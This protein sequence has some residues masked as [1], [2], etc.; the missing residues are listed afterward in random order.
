TE[1]VN[2][3]AEIGVLVVR[4]A[5]VGEGNA[6]RWWAYLP[7][8]TLARLAT[9]GGLVPYGQLTFPVPMLPAHAVRLLRGAGCGP[10]AGGRSCRPSRRSA[11]APGSHSAPSPRRSTCRT[12]RS[13]IGRS[14]GPNRRSPT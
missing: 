5:G 8:G 14:A 9:E 4:R 11:T 13:R 1:R 7:A 12:G 2:A 10:P 6:G 3:D